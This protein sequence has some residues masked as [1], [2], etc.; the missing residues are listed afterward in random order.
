MAS[1]HNFETYGQ[2]LMGFALQARNA[3]LDGKSKELDSYL[4]DLNSMLRK[5]QWRKGVGIRDL[6]PLAPI[7]EMR[8]LLT[9]AE[10]ATRVL[11]EFSFQRIETQ[12]LLP[13]AESNPAEKVRL[14]KQ[15]IQINNN[16][17][18]YLAVLIEQL[19]LARQIL[20]SKPWI[21]PELLVLPENREVLFHLLRRDGFYKKIDVHDIEVFLHYAHLEKCDF[22]GANLK[23]VNFIKQNLIGVNFSKVNLTE[24]GLIHSNLERCN[25]ENANLSHANLLGANLQGANFKGANLSGVVVERANFTGA[26]G[27]TVGQVLQMRDPNKAVGIVLPSEKVIPTTPVSTR[28]RVA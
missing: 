20:Q 28:S 2:S 16:L 1:E 27:L 9:K 23:G 18:R 12:K 26:R 10:A 17:T 14:Y 4:K 24:V 11:L 8:G 3:L 22:S 19:K 6:P 7:K 21:N 25:F 15:F 13:K 5:T